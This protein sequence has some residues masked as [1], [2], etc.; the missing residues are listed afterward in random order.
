MKAQLQY[1]S[2]SSLALFVDWALIYLFWPN[3]IIKPWR[4]YFICRNKPE[5]ISHATHTVTQ[6]FLASCLMLVLKK[7]P[8]MTACSFWTFLIC[9]LRFSAARLW[10]KP[11]AFFSARSVSVWRPSLLP[12]S[13]VPLI[14]ALPELHQMLC[15]W[16]Q[17]L[18]LSQ[19]LSFLFILKPY[20]FILKPY[21][22]KDKQI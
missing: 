20:W 11:F 9:A 18:C 6:L 22:F 13:T 16:V 19:E 14:F 17:I 1:F 2:L 3:K 7:N 4:L 12:K 15:V 8:N 21:W 5:P 10:T